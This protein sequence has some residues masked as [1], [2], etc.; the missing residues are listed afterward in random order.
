MTPACDDTLTLHETASQGPLS[1][2]LWVAK[3]FCLQPRLETTTLSDAPLVVRVR[4]TG[5]RPVQMVAAVPDAI[6]VTRVW[7]AEHSDA[8]VELSQGPEPAEVPTTTVDIAPNT[9]WD[10]AP[11]TGYLSFLAPDILQGTQISSGAELDT[12]AKLH[13]VFGV[14]VRFAATANT[15]AGFV[16]IQQ[17]LKGSIIAL[18]LPYAK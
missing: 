8:P 10:S 1:F 9:E 12:E 17:I 7:D 11:L 3:E 14:E 13:R 4:N 2:E 5:P 18:L 15:G 16:P 6:A